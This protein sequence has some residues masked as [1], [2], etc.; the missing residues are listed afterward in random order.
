MSL[1][2]RNLTK[3]SDRVVFVGVIHTDAESVAHVRKAVREVRPD[4]VAVELDRDRYQQLLHPPTEQEMADA[5][6]SGNVVQDLFQQI[7]L[8]EKRLGSVTGSDAGTEM[9]AAIEEGRKLGAKIALV[10]RPIQTTMQ[11]IMSVPL[12]EVYRMFNMIPGASRDLQ[13][14][15]ADDLMISLKEEGAVEAVMEEFTSEFPNLS[16]ALIQERDNYVAHALCTILN[17]VKGKIVVVLGAGHI[18][19]VRTALSKLLECQAGS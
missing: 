13:D 19:G 15:A 16:N 12:D 14:G 6:P 2:V 18:E 7:A 4:V 9:L 10:D 5:P 3:T 8:L 17:D 11:A 1:Q